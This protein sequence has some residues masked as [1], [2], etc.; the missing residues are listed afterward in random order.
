MRKSFRAAS[1]TAA[2]VTKFSSDSTF[3][4][5]RPAAEVV[6]CVGLDQFFVSLLCDVQVFGVRCVHLR[7]FWDI[8][9]ISSQDIV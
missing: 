3:A 4:V 8:D 6:F 9:S 7:Q 2:C 5:S 1:A